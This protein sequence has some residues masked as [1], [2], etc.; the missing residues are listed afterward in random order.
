MPDNSNRFVSALKK[1]NLDV[2]KQ[3]PKSDLHNHFV[4]GGCREYILKRTGVHIPSMSG[5]FAAMKDMH[6]WCAKYLKAS[7][8]HA[9]VLDRFGRPGLHQIFIEAAFHQAKMDGVT[10]LEIG[11]DVWANQEYYAGDIKAL[12]HAF[13]VAREA[14]AP[15]IRLRFQIGISRHCSINSLE[16]WLKPFW[17]RKEFYSIDLSGDEFAQPI[18]AFIPIYRKAESYGLRLK[19]HVGEW[20][21]AKDVVAAVKLLRLDEIQHGIAAASSRAAMEYLIDNKVRLNICPTSNVK[22][23]R[24]NSLKDHPIGILHRRGVDVTVN[25]DDL[26][27]FDS[28][29]S[30]EYLRLAQNHVLSPEEL[31]VL[32]LNG[33]KKIERPSGLK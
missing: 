26:L 22:L 17:G 14:F 29:V 2:I 4:L 1:G 33:L 15:D 13:Y 9:G 18:E 7:F 20:G 31:D 3:I 23:G 10:L 12:I 25:S 8:V 27:V 5:Y 28:P 11:E 6:A 16:A 19:A 32:R 30:K 24:V 21:T